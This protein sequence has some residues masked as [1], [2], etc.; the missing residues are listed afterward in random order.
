MCPAEPAGLAG[1]QRGRRHPAHGGRPAD[2]RIRGR[3]NVNA[4]EVATGSCARLNLLASRVTNAD[5]IIQRME[6]DPRIRG[7]F[8]VTRVKWRRVRLACRFF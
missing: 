6:E 8:N 4:S 2:P 3:F 1:D 5:G 7:H